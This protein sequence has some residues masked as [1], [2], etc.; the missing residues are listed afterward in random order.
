MKENTYKLVAK[1][2][3]DRFKGHEIVLTEPETRE[4]ALACVADDVG[5]ES[6]KI[7][8][9]A[10]SQTVILTKQKRVKIVLDSEKYTLDGTEHNLK[11]MDVAAVLEIARR[12][13]EAEKIGKPRERSAGGSAKARVEKAEA[14]AA[15]ATNL[16][17]ASYKRL[18]K[19]ARADMR[20]QLIADGVFTAEELDALD[21]E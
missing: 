16:L 5:D 19:S 13:G 7:V 3:P 15:A 21:A 18:N 1:A 2:I 12:A 6:A 20:E 9:L 8:A 14:K 11:E 17:A 10:N 4:E